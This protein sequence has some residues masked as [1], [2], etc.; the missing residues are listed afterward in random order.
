MSESAA[1][2]P[3][4]TFSKYWLLAAP[5]LPVLAVGG[6]AIGCFGMCFGFPCFTIGARYG[7]W[8]NKCPANDM[9]LGAQVQANGLVRGGEGNLQLRPY[10]RYLT[11]ESYWAYAIEGALY[12]GFS[13]KFE[14]L[15]RVVVQ[16]C[17]YPLLF[18]LP[19]LFDRLFL[20]FDVA[21]VFGANLDLIARLR[22]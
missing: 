1:T 2:P 10:A 19:R 6:V 21:T 13:T 20:A 15:D 8:I 7:M 14:L 11:G 9:R 5:A 4:T 22:R 16:V 18:S 17:R 12:R 3:P